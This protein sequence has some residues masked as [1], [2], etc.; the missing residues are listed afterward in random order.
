MVSMALS[1]F[2]SWQVYSDP[3]NPEVSEKDEVVAC[4]LKEV[5]EQTLEQ[6]RESYDK[7]CASEGLK[8]IMMTVQPLVQ[9]MEG[10]TGRGGNLRDHS[11][12]KKYDDP[13]Q[14]KSSS[15]FEVD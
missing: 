14:Q 2:Y 11:L 3:S 10:L 5:A 9:K 13:Q 7:C 12:S 4:D 1:Y 15:H 8:R 6:I